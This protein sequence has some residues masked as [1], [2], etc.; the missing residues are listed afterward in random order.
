LGNRQSPPKKNLKSKGSFAKTTLTKGLCTGKEETK[1]NKE[2]THQEILRK[3]KR[4]T[5]SITAGRKQAASTP[6]YEKK[7]EKP[8]RPCQTKKTGLQPSSRKGELTNQDRKGKKTG[9]N[10][11]KKT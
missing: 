6:S 1:N 11:D 9:A 8:A 10:G 5:T 3:K 2:N 7:K 4:Q